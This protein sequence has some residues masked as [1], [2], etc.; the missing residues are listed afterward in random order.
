M[1]PNREGTLA[2][3]TGS[4]FRNHRR[5]FQP[6]S[7]VVPHDLHTAYSDERQKE[8]PRMTRIVGPKAYWDLPETVWWICARDEGCVTNMQDMSEEDKAA[9]ALFGIKSE[10]KLLPRLGLP[11]AEF[12]AALQ[13]VLAQE[14]E[15][16]PRTAEQIL[17]GRA[18]DDLFK[19][20][21]SGQVRMT[22]IRVGKS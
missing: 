11:E 16:P 18:L 15:K 4:D 17:P 5:P 1:F 13:M 22:A 19:K 8:K 20:V 10:L 12:K 9:L 2:S 3:R 14:S 21:S 7:I 6:P